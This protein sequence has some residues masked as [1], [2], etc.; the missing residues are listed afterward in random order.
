MTMRFFYDMD[1]KIKKKLKKNFQLF[2]N[3]KD[4][5]ILNNLGINCEYKNHRNYRKKTKKHQMPQKDDY[6][7]LNLYYR[8]LKNTLK[9]L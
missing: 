7:R 3:F 6:I 2:S 1:Y 5:N 8:N 9:Y 4:T